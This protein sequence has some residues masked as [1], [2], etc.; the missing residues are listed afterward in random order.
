[1]LLTISANLLLFLL[2][3]GI[4]GMATA[5][6]DTGITLESVLLQQALWLIPA[7]L[8]VGLLTRRSLGAV[9][10]RL[11]LRPL[12]FE[13]LLTGTVGGAAGFILIIGF[14]VLWTRIT[15]PDVLEQQT[16]A[17][18]QLALSVG[19]L[20]MAFAIS[21]LVAVGEEIFFRG[22]LQPAL[23]NLLTSLF[24]TAIHTQ[25]ALTPATGV[26]FIV[27]LGLGWLRSR[28][29]T[30]SAVI[31]HFVYNFAQLGLAVVAGSLLSGT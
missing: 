21:A 31:A 25:Y 23:G 9:I 10:Q 26:I 4:Q 13:D 19:S 1:M 15:P 12:T 30:N 28:Y 29:S 8:G 22:A 16:A 18:S 7:F 17:S 3:G 5:I 27:S 20:G 2:G 11:G 6:Q 24:F 14:A